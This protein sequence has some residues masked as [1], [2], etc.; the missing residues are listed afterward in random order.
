MCEYLVALDCLLEAT[1]Q[2]GN[3]HF[4]EISTP[5]DMEFYNKKWLLESKAISKNLM[6][7]LFQQNAE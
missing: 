4:N 2:H 6:M 1:I 7:G 5:S 3:Q